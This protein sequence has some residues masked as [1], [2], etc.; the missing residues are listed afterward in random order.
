MTHLPAVC[1]YQLLRDL[2]TNVEEI[3]THLLTNKD[4][5]FNN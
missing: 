2:S 5:R 1:L 4:F 3:W